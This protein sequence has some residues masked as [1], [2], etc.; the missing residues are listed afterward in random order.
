[1]IYGI[2]GKELEKSFSSTEVRHL[3]RLLQ[4][5]I[6]EHLKI[7][8]EESAT[9]DGSID[10]FSLSEDDLHD[11]RRISWINFIADCYSSA[12]EGR[13]P[14]LYVLLSLSLARINT[15]HA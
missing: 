8:K 7:L 14:N 13:Q 1:M 10:Q 2:G 3:R 6:L 15:L 12:L 4:R 11:V 5:T 9:N